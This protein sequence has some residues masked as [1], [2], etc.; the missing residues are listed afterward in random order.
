MTNVFWLFAP[1]QV[2]NARFTRNNPTPHHKKQ[3]R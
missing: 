2:N 3:P 1:L